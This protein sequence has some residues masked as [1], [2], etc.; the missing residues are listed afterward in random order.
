MKDRKL[1][2]SDKISTCYDYVDR[3]ERAAYNSNS[4]ESN[5][6]WKKASHLAVSLLQSHN[7]GIFSDEEYDFLKQIAKHFKDD[8][9]APEYY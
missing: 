8:T 2:I 1:S 9:D 3:A 7:P 5:Y 6:Q 4:V